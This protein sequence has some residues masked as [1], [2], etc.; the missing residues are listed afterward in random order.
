[1]MK[2]KYDEKEEYLFEL[3]LGSKKELKEARPELKYPTY[4]DVLDLALDKHLH[5]VVAMR[6]WGPITKN[7]LRDVLNGFLNITDESPVSTTFI[8]INP[9]GLLIIGL[10]ITILSIYLF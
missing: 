2:F 9:R 3:L 8:K 7:E 5:D 10:G 4:G 6:R 1:M